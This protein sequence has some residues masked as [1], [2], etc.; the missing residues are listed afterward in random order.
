MHEQHFLNSR[1]PL[2]RKHNPGLTPVEG[3][4][5]AINCTCGSS[6]SQI[7]TDDLG[8]M[9][10]TG[11]TELPYPAL[12]RE[13]AT[14]PSFVHPTP[15]DPHRRFLWGA[16]MQPNIQAPQMV[17]ATVTHPTGYQLAPQN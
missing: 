1:F 6:G 10:P 8:L 7:R 5:I 16:Q 3:G 14:F 2:A 15:T 9:R 11:T 4:Y 13:G 17:T 12:T